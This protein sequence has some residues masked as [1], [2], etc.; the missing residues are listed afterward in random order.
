M[1]IKCDSIDVTQGAAQSCHHVEFAT[2]LPLSAKVM[3][4]L[5]VQCFTHW[6]RKHQMVF[7]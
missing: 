1:H 4:K 7:L 2:K 5:W 3:N 6:G